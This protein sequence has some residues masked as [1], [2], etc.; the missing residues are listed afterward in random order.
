MKLEK[1]SCM[2]RGVPGMEGKVITRSNRNYKSWKIVVW[3]TNILPLMSIKFYSA[4][5]AQK[6]R[7]KCVTCRPALMVST[8]GEKNPSKKMM[9]GLNLNW[10]VSCSKL[11][12]FRK[13]QPLLKG[14]KISLG[15]KCQSFFVWVWLTLGTQNCLEDFTGHTVVSTTVTEKR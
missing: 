13:N 1:F 10:V 14:R 8:W 4:D 11:G 15:E 6:L 2:L 9:K 7:G 12:R 5:S 3:P